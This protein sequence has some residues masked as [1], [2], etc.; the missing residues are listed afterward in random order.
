MAERKKTFAEQLDSE[1]FNPAMQF[2]S[3]P[4]PQRR[5]SAPAAQQDAPPPGFRMNPMYVE[6]KS[7]RV[8]LLL[9]PSIYAA[10]KE[11]AAREGVSVNE[12][13]NVMLETAVK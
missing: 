3:A 4:A 2:I 10:V 9:K 8:Q 7:R 12:M 13:I 1:Q 11:R 6:I 5:A